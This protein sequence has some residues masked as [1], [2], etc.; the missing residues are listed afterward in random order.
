MNAS[1]AASP[2]LDGH[3]GERPPSFVAPLIG[4]VLTTAFASTVMILLGQF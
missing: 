2:N 1:Q 3:D 4:F